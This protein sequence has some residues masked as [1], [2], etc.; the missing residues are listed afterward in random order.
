[1]P[2]DL[3]D[4]SVHDHQSQ[5]QQPGSLVGIALKNGHHRMHQLRHLYQELPDEPGSAGNG[6]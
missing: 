6:R 4:G 1:V 3:L 2:F 5:A